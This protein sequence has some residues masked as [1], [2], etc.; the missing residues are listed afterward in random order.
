MVPRIR[1]ILGMALAATTS[2]LLSA[3]VAAQDNLDPGVAGDLTLDRIAVGLSFPVGA[4]YLPD[5][6]LLV[7]GQ[8]GTFWLIEQG[9]QPRNV[10]SLTV[11]TSSERGLLGLAVDPE[12]TTTS[13]LYIYY[14][15]G[16]AQRVG[17]V[18]MD[19]ATGMVNTA[20]PTVLIE[21]LAANR[22]HNGG[23]IVFGPD[24]H[25]YIGVGDTGCNCNCSP[26]NNRNNYFPTCLNT[27][28]G[29]ILRIARDGSIPA[30]NPLVGVAMAAACSA[31]TSCTVAGQAPTGMAAPRTEIYNWGFRNP[32][33]FSFDE[34]TGHLWIGDVG[35][36]TWEEIT[37]ST[38][39]GQHHGWPYREGAA[40][41]SPDTCNST[42]PQSGPCRDPAIAYPRNEAPSQSGSVTGGVFSH[43]CSWPEGWRGQYWFG[44]YNKGRIWTVTPNAARDG[45]SGTR[46]V[47]VRQAAGTVHF[48]N[49]PDGAI[50][51]VSVTD[52][53]I[54]RIAPQ[55]PAPCD[56]K[57]AGVDVDAGQEPADAGVEEDAGVVPE[58]DA[59]ESPVDAGPSPDATPA[60]DAGGPAPDAGPAADAG[61]TVDAG[62]PGTE[63]DDG[64]G[65]RGTDTSG[66]GAGLV[67]ILLAGLVITRRRR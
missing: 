39:P 47:I 60:P 50:Y 33:R 49:G 67:A 62:S 36:V 41:Q 8:G 66:A 65:C 35:E 16:G 4:Q 51:Y 59:G 37:I 9:Q 54:W 11:Q 45:I 52:G 38:G 26:G 31:G 55:T 44:D 29:K 3:T 48:F 56:S 42:T 32:W 25:L 46:T 23:S 63:E 14:S 43:H 10:G 21:G 40:G 20:N 5:G 19:Q 22:N 58:E 53:E 12:F 24:G 30:D 64:C 28:H 15:A 2:V 34:A 27:L 13:R 6:R 7:I 17:Y 18:T 1:K 61:V 57:D